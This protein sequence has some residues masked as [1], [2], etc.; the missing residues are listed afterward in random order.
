MNA[1]KKENTLYI[2]VALAALLVLTLILAPKQKNENN[3]MI[4]EFKEGV[5]YSTVSIP[6]EVTSGLKKLGYD[7]NKTFEL[8]SYS[9]PHCYTFENFLEK[10]EESSKET[11]TQLQLGFDGF[12][13]AETDYM[14]NKSLSGEELKKAKLS[15]FETMTSSEISWEKKEQ[16]IAL[17]PTSR[18]LSEDQI[19]SMSLDAS[20]YSKLSRAL[21]LAVD[22]KSTPALYLH[23]KYYVNMQNIRS[24]ENLQAL[25]QHLSER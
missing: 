20:N 24:L 3:T 17:F 21:M 19:I 10:Y 25:S 7:V 13:I 12:P 15:L 1:Q 16:F 4:T 8:F 14:I 23:G 11:V 2:G 6:E 22:L 9:C 18:G 5:H